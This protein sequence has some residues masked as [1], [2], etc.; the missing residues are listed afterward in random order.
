MS[1][2]IKVLVV[3]DEPQ[4]RRFLRASL[5]SRFDLLEAADGTAAVEMI[6]TRNPDIVLL[7]LGLP[8]IDGLDVIKLV[9]K[10]SEIPVIVLSARGEESGIVVALDSG[11]NDY[12]TKPFGIE[13][14]LA[15][16][17]A[18]IRHAQ[19]MKGDEIDD[20]YE[21][22]NL[23][24][25]FTERRVFVDNEEIHLTPIEYKLLTVFVRNAGKVMT[26]RELLR[27]V[28]GPAYERENHYLRVYMGNLRQK[29]ERDPAMPKFFICE[30]SVGYRFRSK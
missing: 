4:I 8:D 24:V 10:S 11:A 6:K 15:R 14:L 3:D 17:R 19:K 30:P 20:E 7:D 12:L 22:E 25:D 5:S 13:E 27:E 26:H 16:T 23:K 28:W 2:L 21:Y 1:N 9:R 18:A 29:I